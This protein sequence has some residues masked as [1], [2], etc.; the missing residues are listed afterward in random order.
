M[1]GAGKPLKRAGPSKS[2]QTDK[3]AGSLSHTGDSDSDASKFALADLPGRGKG[4]IAVRDIERG[5]LLIR[6]KPLFRVPFSTSNPKGVIAEGL[7]AASPEGRAAFFNLSYVGLPDDFDPASDAAAHALAI[8]QTNA[9]AAGDMVG[10]FP[11][12]AR[13]NHGCV[14]AFNSVYSWREREGALVVHALKPIAKGERSQELLTTYFDTKRARDDR[15]AHLKQRYGFEC[16]CSVCALPEAKS[17][18]L[19]RQLTDMA[20]E[21]ARLASW[22]EGKI[23]GLEAIRTVRLLWRLGTSTG[24]HSERGR[25]AADAAW[26][27][28]AHQDASAT[29]AWAALA[30][31]WYAYELGVDSPEVEEA[32]RV[33]SDPTAHPAWGTRQRLAVGDTRGLV[34]NMA[35]S[36]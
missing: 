22:A 26:V 15:R 18:A 13:L 17:T 3:L 4:L 35:V 7:R 27:A 8:F 20:H 5:E 25:L 36:V 9:V 11:R 23:T 24:Y 28:A 12:M 32:E 14:R 21:Y 29:R 10:I 2:T 31:E 16:N 6:E 1:K 33:L 34:A 30:R 19:D